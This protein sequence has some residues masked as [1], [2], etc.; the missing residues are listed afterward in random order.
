VERRTSLRDLKAPDGLI[1]DWA[2][3]VFIPR[4]TVAQTLAFVQNYDHHQEVYRPEVIESRLLSR[5]G[6]VFRIRLRMLKRKGLTVVLNTEHEVR[7]EPAGRLRWRSHSASTRITEVQDPGHAAEREL[8][9]GT[10]RGFLW[11]LNSYWTFQ[12]RDGGTYVEC[13]A[14]SLSRAVPKALSWLIDPIVR[15]LPR[16]SLANTLR[17]TRE[18][19]AA[20]LPEP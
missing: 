9:E 12:E 11:R 20:T 2:G 14:V 3:A 7:Y 13:E 5:D 4:A 17:A 1:H 18:G 8:P 19:L 10:G 6:N 15:H 16:E